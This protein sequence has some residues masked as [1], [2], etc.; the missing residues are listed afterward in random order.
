MVA[1]VNSGIA[2]CS[3]AP[4]ESRDS[5][6]VKDVIDA[7]VVAGTLPRKGYYSRF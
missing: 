7:D 1:G 4:W 2:I 6:D 5:P 3:L